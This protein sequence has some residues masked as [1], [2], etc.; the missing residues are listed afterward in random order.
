MQYILLFMCFVFYIGHISSKDLNKSCPPLVPNDNCEFEQKFDTCQT[1][2]DCSYGKLCCSRKCG[3]RCIKIDR[4]YN[5]SCPPYR[6]DV[7]CKR[8]DRQC[9]NNKD[10][11]DGLICCRVE[12]GTVCTTGQNIYLPRDICSLPKVSETCKAYMPRYYYNKKVKKCLKFIYGGCE[13]NLNNFETLEQCKR[14]YQPECPDCN[15]IICTLACD[16]GFEED[17]NG[18][19]VCKCKTNPCPLPKCPLVQLPY[20]VCSRDTF[21]DFE[22]VKCKGCPENVPCNK[23]CLLPKDIGPCDADIKRYYYDIGTKSCKEFRYGGC[24]GNKNNFITLDACKSSCRKEPCLQVKCSDRCPYG[25]QTTPEGCPT[26]ICKTK[27]PTGEP[28][29]RLNC[30]LIPNR[31]KC[32]RGYFCSVD[33]I[34][35]FAVCCTDP[36][37]PPP[38]CPRPPRGPPGTCPPKCVYEYAIVNGKRCRVACKLGPS[39]PKGEPGKP[40][41]PSLCND[42]IAEPPHPPPPPPPPEAIVPHWH[43][44]T[45][46]NL[47]KN[48][49]LAKENRLQIWKI[50]IC[51]DVEFGTDC[52]PR[53]Y[54]VFIVNVQV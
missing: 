18:C 23:K 25:F 22:G 8:F 48:L 20:G 29:P 30:G 4:K 31:D 38:R 21:F 46:V 37:F 44:M 3:L 36:C 39:G 33:E 7:I 28:L 10:C 9:T 50:L 2:T 54:S 35:R 27:C 26:C 12:C 13:G 15:P 49:T 19:R 32:P 24:E 51:C 45:D 34:D 41:P 11:K 6:T 17:E 52:T 5:P 47:N 42:G 43:H 14:R 1:N 16:F 53:K 40:C